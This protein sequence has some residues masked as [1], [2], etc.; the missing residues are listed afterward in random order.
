MIMILLMYKKIYFD[1]NKLDPCIPSVYVFLLQGYE[2]I[3]PDEVPSRL[4]LI[5]RIEHQIKSIKTF[6][7]M[8]K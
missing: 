4:P 3:F 2:D 5:K 1:T 8:I 7:Y 6:S